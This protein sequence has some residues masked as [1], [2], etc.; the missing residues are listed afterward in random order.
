MY[1]FAKGRKMATHV[2]T[3]VAL[4]AYALTLINRGS[5]SSSD[6]SCVWSFTIWS[7]LL[8]SQ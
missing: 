3:F 4:D 6:P 5:S 7:S 2:G 8:L 1:R